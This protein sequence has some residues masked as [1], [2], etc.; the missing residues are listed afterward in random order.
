MRKYGVSMS[1]RNVGMYLR[2]HTKLNLTICCCVYLQALSVHDE[3][4]GAGTA[5]HTYGIEPHTDISDK[6]VACYK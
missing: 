4:S 1:T 5:L 3:I 2:I 6:Q